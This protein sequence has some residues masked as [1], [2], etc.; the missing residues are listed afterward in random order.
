MRRCSENKSGARS[1]AD[2]WATP[3]Q[4]ADEAGVAVI[5]GTHYGTEK[6]P[7]LAMVDWFRELGLEAEFIP[8]GPK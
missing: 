1:P 4:L 5:D 2:I 7:Q 8:D 3:P 6:P